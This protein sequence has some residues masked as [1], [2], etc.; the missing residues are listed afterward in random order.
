MLPLGVTRKLKEA[1]PPV[2]PTVAMTKERVSEVPLAMT[3]EKVSGFRVL[4]SL[5]NLF[6]L[7]L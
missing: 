1:L 6:D 5:E 4:S 3:K 2:I 7:T